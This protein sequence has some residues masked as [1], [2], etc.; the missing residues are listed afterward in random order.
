MRRYTERHLVILAVA[1]GL[2]LTVLTVWAV[3][4]QGQ[5]LHARELAD[6]RHAAVQAAAERTAA[7]RSDLDRAFEGARVSWQMGRAPELER[8][9]G[10]QRLWSWAVLRGA[11]GSWSPYPLATAR[12]PGD[13]LA[14]ALV[15]AAAALSDETDDDVRFRVV[16][17]QG[18]EPA[19]LALWR[20]GATEW[21]GLA[22][23][24]ANVLER[25]WSAPNDAS[26]R[27]AR[28]GDATDQERLCHLGPQFGDADLVPS[29]EVA[30]RL[31]ADSRRRA[32]LVAATA[33][34]SAAAWA[35]V[36][37]L[38]LRA[39]ARQRELVRLQRRFVADVSHELKTPLTMIRLLAETLQD[40]RVRDP[41]RARTYYETITREAERLSVLLDGI[42]DF[43]RAEAGRKP[44]VLEECDVAD[45]ARQAWA[46]FEPQ[47]AAEGFERKL[48]IAPD[49][50][51]IRADG[52]ALQQVF[53]NLLQ[54][55]YRYAGDGRFVRLSVARDGY[56]IVI[57]I[58]DHGIG[59]TRAQLERLGDSF[60]R[61]EDTRVRQARGTGLGLA[62]VNHIVRA[63]GGKLE[64]QSRPRQGSTFTVWI[65]FEPR[66]QAGHAA[67]R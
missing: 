65:P 36:I 47:F 12:K 21:L 43:S 59:M 1:I 56:L 8:F 31:A 51:A 20:L 22:A 9:L 16:R 55:A 52:A 46:L 45:V 50:P 44:P 35:I 34:G 11:D 39:V 14:A 41:D 26:W 30:G 32:A 18:G 3:A 28:S 13:A 4:Q 17:S 49:L 2:A 67:Q 57:T 10:R 63:H 27:I 19:V 66:T 24:A 23:P 64:V 25:Y 61:A 38:M 15:N 53:V 58:E 7:L 5:A 54:N 29:D 48:E 60:Y 33:V 62:I 42:L 6:L 40:G 37:W